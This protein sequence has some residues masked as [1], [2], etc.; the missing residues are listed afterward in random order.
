MDNLLLCSGGDIPLRL[1]ELFVK[2]AIITDLKG[3]TREEVLL[4]LLEALRRAGRLMQTG[5]IPHALLS[6]ERMG[7][8]GIGEGVAIPHVCTDGIHQPM[9]AFGR[10]AQGVDFQ[11]ID[12]KPV[13]LIFL[14]LG[15]PNGQTLQLKILGRLA[16]IFHSPSFIDTLE[17]IVSCSDFIPAVKKY[18]EEY[19]DIE[20][21][22]DMPSVCVAGAGHGGLAMA[23]HLSLI[24]CRVN[25]YNRSPERLAAIRMAGGIHVTGEVQ[26]FARLN[27]ITTDPAEALPDADLVMIVVPA[28]AHH[29]MARLLGPHLVE[30][31]VVILNPG[32]TG[33][34]LEFIE[35]L[36]QLRINT[37]CFL[38]ETETLVY[39]SRITNP[40]Q[41][42]IFRIKNAVPMATFP[43]YNI[44]DVLEILRKLLPYFVPGDNVLKTGL[45]NISAVFH[46]ALM[47]MNAAWIEESHGDLDFYCQ[48]ISPSVAQILQALDTERIRVAEKMGIRVLSAREW[49]YQAYS[50][51]G[52]NLFEAIQANSGYR[53]IKAP[54][55]L[56]H[57]YIT[58]DVPAS[59]VPIASLGDHLGVP[60]PTMKAVIHLASLLHGC[61][62]QAMGRTVE[63]LGLAGLT[64]PQIRRFIEEGS[65]GSDYIKS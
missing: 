47:L 17:H 56:D 15:R 18:E 48:G 2:E 40:G 38:G 65:L 20:P 34:S 25:L 22:Q 6:R 63:K 46:P 55:T 43:A 10:S 54:N 4:E 11:S 5:E 21:P 60:V 57:R 33:G 3:G 27:L 64:V 62:Y 16:R 36:R 8:S 41:V 9:I 19:E 13:H 1:H 26:G 52:D 23:G 32:G 28:T 50:A 7:T 24:G 42:R 30:G 61:N 37:F 31:Q 12:G 59:L 39:A 49:L 14:I 51:A 58:E 45:S 53:G 44:P 29:N 35:V